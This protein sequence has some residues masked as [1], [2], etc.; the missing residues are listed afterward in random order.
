MDSLDL[1]QSHVHQLIRQ[2]IYPSDL[3]QADSEL[4][5]SVYK[6]RIEHNYVSIQFSRKKKER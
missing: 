3:D 4:C 1:N 2:L 6:N 5:A